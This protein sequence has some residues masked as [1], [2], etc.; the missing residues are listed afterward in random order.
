MLAGLEFLGITLDPA[1]NQAAG[2]E[3][4]QRISPDGAPVAVW[5]VPADEELQIA[6]AVASLLESARG[7]S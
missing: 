2:P 7:P 3:R 5:V 6:R 4:P 1:R